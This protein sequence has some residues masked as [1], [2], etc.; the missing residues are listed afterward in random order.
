MSMQSSD[1][2]SNSVASLSCS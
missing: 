1:V 2:K